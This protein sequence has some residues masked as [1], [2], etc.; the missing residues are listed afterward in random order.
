MNQPNSHPSIA[1]THDCPPV[2]GGSVVLSSFAQQAERYDRMLG[3][4]GRRAIDAAAIAAGARVLDVG[5]GAGGST[6]DAA[7]RVGPGGHVLGIDV[8]ADSL[9]VACRRAA[10]R[11]FRQIDWQVADAATARYAPASYDAIVSR[12]GTLHFADPL[13]AHRH[14][15][16]ALRPGA[17]LSLACGGPITD[18]C[19]AMLIYRAVASV[20]PQVPAPRPGHGPFVYSDA[21]AYRAVLA[22]A[23]LV[24]VCIEHDREP[25]WVGDDVDEAIEFFFETDGKKLDALLH[26]AA[27]AR[28][29]VALSATLSRYRRHDGVWLPSSNWVVSAIR[30]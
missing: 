18:D 3:P 22:A 19:W 4:V 12:F 17:R 24:D 7:E 21:D 14:L 25:V 28:L 1:S 9:A 27:H 5:C 10:A 6:I 11:G 20:L 13:A 29:C 26:D 8:D 15:A 2:V 16:R 30:P 23:G